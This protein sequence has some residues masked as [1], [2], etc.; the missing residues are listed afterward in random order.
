L[1]MYITGIVKN[2]KHKLI[3]INGVGDHV[4]MLIGY[5][6]NQNLSDLLKDIKGSSSGWINSK[7]FIKG[8]FNWQE[9]YGA[10]S[11]S[12]SQIDNVVKYINNQEAHHSKRS[13]EEE[14]LELLEKFEIEYDKRYILKG[15]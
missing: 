13:F 8:K 14:Y 9:G 10:F 11:Y 7:M 2:N 5:K 12:H 15:V 1:F 6:P 4:H 3:A